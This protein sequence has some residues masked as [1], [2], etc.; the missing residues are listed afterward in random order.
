MSQEYLYVYNSHHVI[1]ATSRQMPRAPR[2]A[3]CLRHY[4][5]LFLRRYRINAAEYSHAAVITAIFTIFI[6]YNIVYAT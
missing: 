4:D 2:L 6:A 3:I 5:T 1:A